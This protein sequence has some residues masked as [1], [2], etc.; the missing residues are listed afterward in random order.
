MATLDQS[1]FDAIADLAYRESGLT[2]VREKAV[3]VQS[4]LRHRLR[5]LGFQDFSQ[6]STYVASQDGIAERAQLICALTTNVSQFFRETHHFDEMVKRVREKLPFLRSGGRFRIW[7]A[8]CSNG[9][10]PLSAAIALL[11]ALPEVAELDLRIL[12]TD[13]DTQVIKFARTACYSERQLAGIPAHLIPKYFAPS[14]ENSGDFLYAAKPE[15]LRLIRY[16]ALNLLGDWPMKNG[17][18]VIFCRNVVIYF[19][20][21]TQ[22]TLWPRF[23]DALRPDGVLFLGHSERVAD[24]KTHSFDFVGPTTYQKQAL[25]DI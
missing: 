22:E 16:N 12:G 20:L 7:S 14:A 11:E 8:G 21:V 3:M 18:D 15:V 24:P 2:L 4:R 13:I 10:E 9:Q 1:S 5:A 6:Y 17:F 25:L 23:R 19:D